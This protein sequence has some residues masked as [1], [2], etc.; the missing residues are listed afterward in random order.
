MK[1]AVFSDTHRRI[2]GAIA[3]IRQY[4]PD[5]I[6]HL[7][8]HY[9]D[10][11]SIHNEFP[12]IPMECVPGNC[13]YV[14]EEDV[15]K[16]IEPMGVKI[17]LT[18]GHTCNVKYDMNRLLNLAYYSFASIAL[19]GHTHSPMYEQITLFDADS[20]LHLINPGSAGQGLHPTWARIEL[21]DGAIKT[22]R[23]MDI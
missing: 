7:G 12:H 9:R 14:P 15:V 11:Q 21:E 8:D 2:D 16:F 1:I 4:R 10:A 20:P 13:D 23:L 17:M 6:I 18:H 5:L 22:I 19:F 3:A